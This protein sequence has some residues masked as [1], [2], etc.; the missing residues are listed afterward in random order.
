MNPE[1]ICQE[2]S[3]SLSIQHSNHIC[4]EISNL[5]C[6]YNELFNSNIILDSNF[7]FTQIQLLKE[8]LDKIK[9][10]FLDKL[11]IQ[12]KQYNLLLDEYQKSNPNWKLLAQNVEIG[13]N[14]LKLKIDCADIL[15]KIGN[16]LK[17]CQNFYNQNTSTQ[18][19]E[20]RIKI[21][22][23]TPIQSQTMEEEIQNIEI[24]AKLQDNISVGNTSEKKIIQLQ[25]IQPDSTLILFENNN[26]MNYNLISKFSRQRIILCNKFHYFDKK[27]LIQYNNSNQLYQFDSTEKVFNQVYDFQVT[28]TIWFQLGQD[29]MIYQKSNLHFYKKSFKTKV[30]IQILQWNFNIKTINY[31]L[32]N[33]LAIFYQKLLIIYNLNNLSQSEWQLQIND[34]IQEIKQN[35]ND[36][37]VLIGFTHLYMISIAKKSV[38]K[39]FNFG[40]PNCLIIPSPSIPYLFLI[41]YSGSVYESKAYFHNTKQLLSNIISQHPTAI[42]MDDQIILIGDDLGFIQK[43]KY[44]LGK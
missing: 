34:N 9:T 42:F 3:C 17:I 29:D 23:N 20:S 19:S 41:G 32:K 7:Y 10:T 11:S 30:E 40:Q 39:K 28:D 18:K 33:H 43:F 14:G 13:S 31:L 25:Y 37:L 8:T 38:V 16:L 27:L 24:K 44:A 2:P 15:Y 5:E 36:Y 35:T 6:Y 12:Q 26:L 22:I 21:K 1:Y 4:F